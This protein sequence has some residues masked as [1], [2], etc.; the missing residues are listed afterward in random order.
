MRIAVA[1]NFPADAGAMVCG[2]V[3]SQFENAERDGKTGE[4]VRKIFE[5][6]D[7]RYAGSKAPPADFLAMKSDVESVLLQLEEKL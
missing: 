1:P 4:T 7:V 3:L 5:A 6:A 2:D